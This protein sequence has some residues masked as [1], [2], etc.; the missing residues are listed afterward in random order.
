MGFED[1]LQ[2]IVNFINEVRTQK[3]Q[4]VYQEYAVRITEYYFSHKDVIGQLR[5]AMGTDVELFSLFLFTLQFIVQ[6][7]QCIYELQQL[8]L[9]E[10]FE[11]FAALDLFFQIASLAFRDDKVH[12]SYSSCR[13]VYEHLLERV[14]TELIGDVDYLPYEQRNN[15]RIILAT[16]ALLELYHAPTRL[17]F[18]MA[19][20]L[21]KLGYEVTIV[22]NVWKQPRERAEQYCFAPFRPNYNKDLGSL[23]TVEYNS[24]HYPVYQVFFGEGEMEQQRQLLKRIYDW[25]PLFVWYI[26]GSL[27]VNNIYKRVVT[28]VSMGC[29]DGYLCSCTP[30]LLS[31]MQS[32]SDDVRE[33][34]DYAV[35]HGQKL[36]NIK[37]ANKFSRSNLSLTR[38][39][40]GIPEQSFAICVVGNRLDA[41]LSL[42]FV[43]MLCELVE[44]SELYHIVL[45]GKC[46]PGILQGMEEARYTSLGFRT[47]LVDVLAMTDLFVNP[48]R[49]G[50]GGGAARAFAV[51]VPA[52][53]YPDCDVSNVTGPDFCCQNLE[54]MRELIR[55]YA[56]DSE[57]YRQQQERAR[58]VYKEREEVSDHAVDEVGRMLEQVTTWL[59]SG[60]IV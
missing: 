10:D 59:E 6:D 41:E 3:R 24:N 20:C 29:T 22:V 57:F 49:Q 8:S 28:E 7:P 54:E 19:D 21:H 18:T 38:K 32:N 42:E 31:Y 37:L 39:D 47:D 14:E 35:S 11:L 12:L 33:S 9:R 45:V 4:E 55:R 48:P 27:P 46:S 34:I 30:V 23:P 40:L 60:E 58:Q 5:A 26:G 2:E 50:G 36:C 1:F 43:Q 51:G 13:R 53:T 56:H 15:K 52:V 16:D 44:Q 25:K 17:V